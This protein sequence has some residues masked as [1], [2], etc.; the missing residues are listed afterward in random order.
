MLSI[1]YPG[2]F[3]QEQSGPKTIEPVGTS[4]AAFIGQAPDPAAPT[5]DAVAVNN[6]SEFRTR[7]AAGDN[8]TSTALSHAVNGFFANGGSRCFIVNL[9]D[10]DAI[11]GNDRPRTGL[12]LL[13]EIDEISIVAAPGRTDPASH[14][15]LISHCEGQGDR[16]CIHD[17]ADVK[18]TELL[19]TVESVPV[20][21]KGKD[22]DKEIDPAGKPG[23]AAR[24]RLAASGLGTAYFPNIIVADALHPNLP[25]VPVSVSGH[26]AGIWARTDGK[27]GVHK[28]PA[29]EPVAGALNLTYRV[30]D[31]EQA[32]LNEKGINCIRFFSTEG[33]LVWG[34]RTLAEPS[35]EWK[36][37]NVRRLLIMIEQ[38][39][40]RNTRWVV[41]EP[42]DRALWRSVKSEVNRFLSN[43]YR[44]GA[45]MGATPDEAFFVKCDD[46][47]N[48]QESID[49]GQLVTVIGVAPVKPAEFIIFKIGQTAAGAQ[50]EAL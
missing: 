43:V 38:S 30:T 33:I 36:Y 12:K 18:N 40:K 11:V 4:V 8:L 7:F 3:I 45:L 42:N 13:E 15:A 17:L 48:P 20:P 19:K 2:V 50:I 26:M 27:R 31:A 10:T 23:V 24:P 22:K 32:D 21:L 5:G 28:A 49:L 47:T 34:A 41:F 16:V 6:W 1:R 14:E 9:P 39:I 44:D 25:P 29:N 35:S 37:I 46:E